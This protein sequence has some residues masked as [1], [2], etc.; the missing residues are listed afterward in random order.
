MFLI[1]IL[2]VAIVVLYLVFSGL[3]LVVGAGAL[4]W[5][6]ILHFGVGPTVIGLVVIAVC[7]YVPQ[8]GQSNWPAC[9]SERK[10]G[11]QM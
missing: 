3:F 1:E 6:S 8:I 10:K 11:R 9:V 4:I 7:I 5:L 2:L